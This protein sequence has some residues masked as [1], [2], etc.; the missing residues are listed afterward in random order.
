MRQEPGIIEVFGWLMTGLVVV[1]AVSVLL[2][3]LDEGK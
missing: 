1:A 3:A 2:I